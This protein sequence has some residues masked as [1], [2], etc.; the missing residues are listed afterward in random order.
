MPSLK[1]YL[2]GGCLKVHID[3]LPDGSAVRLGWSQ[4]TGEMK[5]IEWYTTF[6][7]FLFLFFFFFFFG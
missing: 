2:I 5:T 3:D 4:S 1:I 6:F 7:F